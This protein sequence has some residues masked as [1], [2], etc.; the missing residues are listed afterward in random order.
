MPNYQGVWDITTQFQYAAEWPVPFPSN[1]L[2]LFVSAYQTNVLDFVAISTTGNATDFGDAT[3]S[4]YYV[5]GHGNATRGIT[6]YGGANGTGTIDYVEFATKANA[7]DFGDTA[8]AFG[9]QQG[10]G[11]GNNTRGVF[12]GATANN[13]DIM[14]YVTMASLGNGTDFGNLSQARAR[15]T[16]TSSTTRGIFAGGYTDSASFVDTIDYITIGSTGNASDFGNL[17]LARTFVAGAASAT[18]GLI[19]GGYND[20]GGGNYRNTI[21]YITIGSTGNATDFGD[22]TVARASLAGTSNTTR[23]IFGGGDSGSA[24]NVIDYVTI[25]STGN[26]S[27]FGD[28]T[29]V[30]R[31]FDAVGSATA[32]GAA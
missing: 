20:S 30:K 32:A 2:G 31:W 23:A 16:A 24:V 15:L 18:R 13:S 28:L 10:G 21:D 22:L 5:Q 8:T 29:V 1:D 11:C 25:G 26:A 6:A 9:A 19:A 12:G 27:D 17:T 4:K 14:E 7:A 3:A